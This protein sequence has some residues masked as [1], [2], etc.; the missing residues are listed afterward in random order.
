ML[1][2]RGGACGSTGADD[3]FAVAELA[4]NSNTGYH[5]QVALLLGYDVKA[6]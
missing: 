6:I 2:F 5:R 4:V 3:L 1:P